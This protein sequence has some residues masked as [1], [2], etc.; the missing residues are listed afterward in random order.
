[1]AKLTCKSSFGTSFYNTIIKTNVETLI[2][3]LGE[4]TYNDNSGEDKTN[5]EWV[6]E[7]EN[8]D[9]FTVYDW[10]YCRPISKTEMIEWH[11]GG[12]SKQITEIGLD[13]LNILI[14]GL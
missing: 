1:M 9:V 8:E 2:S 7:N 12:N 11:I 6:C 4:P 14:S 13:E 3:I 5:Y 10:K